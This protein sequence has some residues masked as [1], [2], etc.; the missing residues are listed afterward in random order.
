M[1]KSPA[2][3]LA[4]YGH[5][6]SFLAVWALQGRAEALKDERFCPKINGVTCFC[7]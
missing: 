5:V 3:A 7:R 6:F 4:V 1:I 2:E